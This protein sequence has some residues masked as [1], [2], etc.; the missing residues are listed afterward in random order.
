MKYIMVGFNTVPHP[1]W[2]IHL[3]PHYPSVVGLMSSFVD[4]FRLVVLNL[5]NGACDPVIML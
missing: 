3:R 4:H 2:A 1:Y 5:P